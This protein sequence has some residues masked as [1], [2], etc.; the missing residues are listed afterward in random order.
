[1]RDPDA[2]RAMFSA[3]S[4][5]YD[6]LNRLL[7]AGLDRSWR[8]RAIET[9]PLRPGA[10]ALDLCGGTGDLA[11]ELAR[12]G[13]RVICCD[14]AGPM[15]AR[16][17]EKFDRLAARSN[18]PVPVATP[19]CVLADGLKLPFEDHTFEAVTVGFGIR[20]LSNMDDGLGEIRRVLVPGGTAGLLEFSH[21]TSQ[22]L[23]V[24]YGFYLNRILPKVGDL[25]SRREGP[26]GYLA[27]TIGSFPRPQALA[28]QMTARGF[29]DVRWTL[30]TGGIVAL[31]LARKPTP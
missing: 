14:F 10:L 7:S 3:I 9:M 13:A 18:G 26:Y 29:I 15:L 31:H 6:L 27:R 4:P 30:F 19:R 22:P 1:M 24:L 28:D 12:R 8:R 21:P 25:I 20:N 23:A 5:R 17:R 2:V 11:T 16:A